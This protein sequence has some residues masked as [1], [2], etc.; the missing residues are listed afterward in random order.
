MSVRT[1]YLDAIA[2]SASTSLTL[3]VKTVVK[4][5]SNIDTIYYD[6][7]VKTIPDNRQDFVPVFNAL[8]TLCQQQIPLQDHQKK[9]QLVPWKR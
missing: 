4:F 3:I 7:S 2:D 9:R 8:R 5:R 1:V 6:E